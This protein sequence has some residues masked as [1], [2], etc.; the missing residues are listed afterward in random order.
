MTLYEYFR[1]T[2]DQTLMATRSTI[3]DDFKGGHDRPGYE[4]D[5][6]NEADSVFATAARNA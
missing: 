1:R 4:R 2:L 5:S 6:E 3:E